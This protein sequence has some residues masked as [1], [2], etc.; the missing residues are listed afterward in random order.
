[1]FEADIA[2]LLSQEF[3][4]TEL[5]GLQSTLCW[6]AKVIRDVQDSQNGGLRRLL[7]PSR[8][9]TSSAHRGVEHSSENLSSQECMTEMFRSNTSSSVGRRC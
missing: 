2:A 5:Y 4:R 1:M 3:S 7:L 8:P 6:L 9:H